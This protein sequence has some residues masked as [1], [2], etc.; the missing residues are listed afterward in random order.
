MMLKGMAL[1]GP[2][3]DRK[4]TLIQ[5][6][7]MARSMAI[8]M[9]HFNASQGVVVVIGDACVPSNFTEYYSPGVLFW[10][11]RGGLAPVASPL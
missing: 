9:A 3:D 2:G 4:E 8:N 10:H 11:K 5:Q 6:F 7:Q 1:P